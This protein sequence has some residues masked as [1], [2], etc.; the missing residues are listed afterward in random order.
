MSGQGEESKARFNCGFNGAKG[1]VYEGG[2]RVPMI[3]RWPAGLNASGV[4]HEMAHFVDWL[5]TLVR[6]GEPSW[7]PA[8][9]LDGTD[10]SGLFRGEALGDRP[11]RFWQWNR[12]D[13]VGTCNA[14]MREGDWK[15]VRPA[16]REAMAVRSEDSTLDQEVKKHPER[17][18]ALPRRRGHIERNIPAARAPL[19]F[20]IAADPFEQHDLAGTEPA[21]AARMG[22]KLETWF[23]EVE[24]ERAEGM[25]K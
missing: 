6:L 14:A 7:E 20:N 11:S 17:L 10:V 1:L 22:V 12:Y 24:S 25:E 23:E 21:R 3:L 15:L 9:H 4:R 13:P 5:P 8:G 19:L 18:G 16:I 2:I